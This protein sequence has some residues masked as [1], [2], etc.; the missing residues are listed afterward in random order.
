MMVSISDNLD[1]L[2]DDMVIKCAE[3]EC[4]SSVFFIIVRVTKDYKF[5]MLMICAV[6]S[7]VSCIIICTKKIC[8]CEFSLTHSKRSIIVSTHSD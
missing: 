2:E 6:L 3:C 1:A 5:L 7:A 4:K 8:N